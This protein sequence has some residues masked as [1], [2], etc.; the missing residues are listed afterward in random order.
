MCK[1]YNPACQFGLWVGMRGISAVGSARHSY[2]RGQGF[3]SPMLHAEIRTG[4]RFGFL[5]FI[6]IIRTSC[7]LWAMGSD[8]FFISNQTNL[9]QSLG[10]GPADR[11]K[12][13]KRKEGNRTCIRPGVPPTVFRLFRWASH[14]FG[15]PIWPAHAATGQ[16]PAERPY[17]QRRPRCPAIR[18]G[19]TSPQPHPSGWT[20]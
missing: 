16:I 19:Q 18:T 11:E 1:K 20:G 12:Q 3:E 17:S 5:C 7:S 8:Y 14:C 6:N 15:Q 2:C 13:R 10:D 4:D 9:H